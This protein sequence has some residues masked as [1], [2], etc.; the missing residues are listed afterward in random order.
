MLR[1]RLD[2]MLDALS[3]LRRYRESIDRETMIGDR[4]TQHMVSHALYVAAQ[5]AID[6][7]LHALADTEAPI[8]PT[9]RDAFRQLA[10]AG[11]VP[12][13]LAQRLEG[14]AGLRNVLAHHYATIDYGLVHDAMV[15]DLD[16]LEQLATIVAGWLVD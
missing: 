5:A 6:V 4:D 9:Y 16:D 1:Q 15:R 2:I 14:W 8:A 7:A 11:R 13:E 10:V 3:D 12:K